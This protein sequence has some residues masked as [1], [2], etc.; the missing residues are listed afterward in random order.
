M[1]LFQQSTT[2][3]SQAKVKVA[4]SA[5]KEDNTGFLTRAGESLQAAMRFWN[6]AAYW[7]FTRTL[8]P[9]VAV[10]GTVTDTYDLPYD[11]RGLYS[12]R[13]E[14][15]NPQAL[16]YVRRRQVDRIYGVQPWM[17]RADY[18]DLFSAGHLGK[19]RLLNLS[20]TNTL[21]M[22]YF[23]RLRVPCSLSASVTTTNLAA[24]IT[25]SQGALAGAQIGAAITGTGIPAGTVLQ[26]ISETGATMS[27]A[28]T[29]SGSITA[30]I[31]SDSAFLDIPCDYEDG[32]IAL[33]KWHFLSDNGESPE[34]L[35]AWNAYFTE[36]LDKAKG[37]NNY[38]DDEE[39]EFVALA[40]ELGWRD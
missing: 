29:A 9:D 27:A 20:N 34:R 3:F 21:R 2:T 37:E 26:A 7:D 4:R 18:Y 11:A 33:A 28:A 36:V 10:D 15:T 35:A 14:G 13:M 5:G 31:G 6:R 40:D 1:S 23:R 39:V 8:H 17:N 38:N 12:V 16:Q 30:T 24:T 19:I 22:R 32:V 25:C